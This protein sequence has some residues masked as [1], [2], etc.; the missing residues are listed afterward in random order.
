MHDVGTSANVVRRAVAAMFGR[1][2]GRILV[3][4]SGG[5]DSLAL[6]L[7]AAEVAS[8]RTGV[9]SLDHGL[10]PSAAAEVERVGELARG[11]GLAFH[12]EALGLTPGPGAEARARV[13]RYAAL[14]RIAQREG[15]A[16][17]ATAHTADDQAET[18]L[19]R[20]AR[21][22]ALRGAAAIRAGGPRLLRPLLAV[23]RADTEALVAAAGLEPVRDP[24]NDDPG[25][26]RTRIRHH[27]LPVLRQAAGS[28]VVERLARFARSAAE[29][30][31]LLAGLAAQALERV[32]DGAGL[33]AVGVR[34]LAWPI[35]SRLLRD[36]LE[37]M[38]HPVSDHLLRDVAAAIDRGGRT[39]LPGRAVLGTEGGWVRVLPRQAPGETATPELR[40]GAPVDFG[41]FRVWLGDGPGIPAGGGTPPLTVRTRRP[42]DRVGPD[43][44]PT[45]RVQDVL[46]DAGIPAEA[47][48]GW[49]LVADARGR[50]L[51]VV[52]LWPRP[53]PGTAPFLHAEPP[54]REIA[55]EAGSGEQP[56]L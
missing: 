52:G 1:Q 9:A 39:G 36:W 5:V 44:G 26:F 38:G 32:R 25:L 40:P 46:V 43:G 15:Y 8:D 47:R 7:S 50:V 28:G 48:G 2:E 55:P 51:W 22:S 30:E 34:A 27:V 3:A 11:R 12:T 35:R 53:H 17:I 19:M 18:L 31:E 23:R 33:D 24:S 20:L 16:A 45:R 10:R 29:D 41:G 6:L 49:P 4:V 13:A 21:G 14:E 56:S 37:G 54:A 42:G